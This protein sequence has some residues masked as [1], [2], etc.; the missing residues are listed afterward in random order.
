[1]TAALQLRALTA[2]DAEAVHA[3]Y[4]ATRMPEMAHFPLGEAERAQF[5]RLQSLAQQAHHARHYP[6][7]ALDAVLLD[8]RLIGRLCVW[9]QP[10]EIRLMDIRLLPECCGAGRGTQLLAALIGEAARSG[11]LLT[12]HAAVASRARAWYRRLGFVEGVDDGATVFMALA[13][14]PRGPAR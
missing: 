7:A 12:L 13:A 11:A 5:L 6:G 3:L 10:G 9:R 4:A 14:P 1:M 2:A 8:G